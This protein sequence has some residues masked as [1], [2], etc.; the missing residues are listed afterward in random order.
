MGRLKSD[1][2]RYTKS[3]LPR[4]IA[5]PNPHCFDGGYNMAP[6]IAKVLTGK[7]KTLQVTMNC[8]GDE[9]ARLKRTGKP[10]CCN[11]ARIE[12]TASHYEFGR[13]AP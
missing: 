1:T 7:L 6:L 3:N 13:S 4:V 9:G 11:S 5:C 12:L 2:Q 10:N 8:A